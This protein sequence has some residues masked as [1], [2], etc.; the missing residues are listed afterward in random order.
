[1]SDVGTPAESASAGTGGGAIEGEGSTQ[2]GVPIEPSGSGTWPTWR[3][4]IINDFRSAKKAKANDGL[5][6]PTFEPPQWE[7]LAAAGTSTILDATR[8]R[9]DQA[10]ARMTKAEER[11]HRLVSVGLTLLAASFV[12]IGYVVRALAADG[13][14]WT[15]WPFL[16]LAGLTVLL[17][18]LTVVQAL[19]VDR[20]G[21]V[22]T[23]D[24]AQ[25]APLESEDEQR[26]NLSVQEHRA[27]QMANWTARNKVTEVL[28][29]RAWLTRG[30][31]ALVLCGAVA[32]ATWSLDRVDDDSDVP[33]SP[34]STITEV[35]VPLAST[36]TLRPVNCAPTTVPRQG[37][38]SSTLTEPGVQP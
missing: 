32:A 4:K 28:Q 13:V 10:E 9:H 5:S 16:A 3:D 31:S 36:T 1:M 35:S 27:S 19:G 29:A 18:S 24:P 14:S 20:V 17:L 25:A 30:I 26:R 21:F 6:A 8:R 2:A 34:P 15:V 37:P 11:A 23:A 33:S 12:V 22:Q 7:N 38:S